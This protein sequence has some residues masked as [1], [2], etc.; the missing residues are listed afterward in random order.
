MINYSINNR[1]GWIRVFGYG[2]SWK[3]TSRHRLRFSERNGYDTGLQVGR[4][5]VSLLT[6]GVP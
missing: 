4:Y 6:R 5:Y 1:R 2:V 3:D